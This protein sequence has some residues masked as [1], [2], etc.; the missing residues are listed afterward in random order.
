MHQNQ[1]P[2]FIPTEEEIQKAKQEIW[3]GWSE[4]EERSRAGTSDEPYEIP[5]ASPMIPKNRSVKKLP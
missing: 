4:R 2:A 5:S 1:K 3:D